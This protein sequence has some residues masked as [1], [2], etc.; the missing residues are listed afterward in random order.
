MA[1]Y[2]VKN[3]LNYKPH[4]KGKTEKRAEPGETVSDLPAK[5]IGWLI[6][7]GHIAPVTEGKG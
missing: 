3:G 5:S 2:L 7:Q 6:E 1:T 4:G